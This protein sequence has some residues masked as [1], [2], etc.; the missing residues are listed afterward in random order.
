LALLDSAAAAPYPPYPSILRALPQVA[1]AK[2]KRKSQAATVSVDSDLREHNILRRYLDLSKFIELLR[3]QS[4]YLCRADRFPD[5]FEGVLTPGI[6]QAI[7]SAF[8]AGDAKYDADAF[9]RRVREGIYV[10]CWSLGAQDN[11]ALWQLYGGA[12]ASVAITT[13]VRQLI[14]TTMA[15]SEIVEIAKV[16]YIDHFKNPNMVVGSIRTPYGLRTPR[17]HLRTKSGSS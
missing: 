15:R 11:M 2:R 16:K 9:S 12:S 3:A 4:L 1:M 14:Q 7:D 10:N 13:T 5:R 6:R 8:A 17:I